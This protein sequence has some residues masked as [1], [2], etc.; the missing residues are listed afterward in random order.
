MAILALVGAVGY[1]ADWVPHVIVPDLYSGITKKV[2]NYFCF[3]LYT[4]R[5][6]LEN[7]MALNMLSITYQLLNQFL[8]HHKSK[9]KLL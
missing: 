6:Y 8:F 5:K 4:N 7:L 1:G 2:W 3:A 9:H